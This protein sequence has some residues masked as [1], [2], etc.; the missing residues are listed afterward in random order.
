MRPKCPFGPYNTL[1]VM[2]MTCFNMTAS[3]LRQRRYIDSLVFSTALSTSG[4]REQG[5]FVNDHQSSL[6]CSN[7]EFQVLCHAGRRII[8]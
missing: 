5:L 8:A 3:R 6:F 4:L 1:M 7:L 2:Q